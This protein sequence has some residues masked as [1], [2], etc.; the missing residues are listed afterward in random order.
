MNSPTGRQIVLAARPNGKPK[1]TDFRLEEA[2][3]STPSFGQILLGVQYLSLDPYMRGR[4]DDRKSYAK[5]LQIGDAMVGEAVAKVIASNHPDYSPGDIVLAQTGWCSHAL[6]DL[7]GQVGLPTIP[8]AGDLD[9]SPSLRKLDPGAAPVTTAL[10]VLG[11]P[12]FTAY[13]G[14]RLIG[15]PKRGE[16]CRGSCRE[17]TSWFVG[18]PAGQDRRRESGRHRRWPE[19]MRI[20]RNRTALRRC[21]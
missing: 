13:A 1:L 6:L 8:H 4:M 10:G 21:D 3:V 11:M 16:N 14:L 2:A 19:E 18:R 9:G 7:S 15:K 5:P 20:R 12:G 17:R